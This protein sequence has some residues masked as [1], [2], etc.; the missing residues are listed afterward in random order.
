MADAANIDPNTG[1]PIIQIGQKAVKKTMEV[2]PDGRPVIQ[3]RPQAAAAAVPDGGSFFVS[4]G[5]SVTNPRVRQLA[6]ETNARLAKLNLADAKFSFF[7]PDGNMLGRSIMGRESIAD[8]PALLVAQNA[9][10]AYNLPEI[11]SI[12]YHLKGLDLDKAGEKRTLIN[13]L[14]GEGVSGN[15]PGKIQDAADFNFF[16]QESKRLLDIEK[17]GRNLEWE[18]EYDLGQKIKTNLKDSIPSPS[19]SASTILISERAILNHPDRLTSVVSHEYTH[20]L[21][22]LSGAKDNQYDTINQAASRVMKL[23]NIDA[24]GLRQLRCWGY[25]RFSFLKRRRSF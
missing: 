11:Q 12:A 1:R 13:V 21:T 17:A 7:G 2:S 5:S 4:V 20:N 16:E 15:Y 25:G 24:Q 19:S 3:L 14:K 23:K 22:V 10:T 18:D 9:P 6:E 8:V